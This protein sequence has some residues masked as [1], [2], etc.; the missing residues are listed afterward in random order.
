[1]GTRKV[2][3]RLNANHGRKRDKAACTNQDIIEAS[4]LQ[5]RSPSLVPSC[6]LESY[7]LQRCYSQIEE[8]ALPNF[9]SNAR[10]FFDSHKR[11]RFVH[12][13]LPLLHK[14]IYHGKRNKCEMNIVSHTTLHI[15]LVAI[16]PI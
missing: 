6:K 16:L 8:L 11:D 10:K 14:H 15:V 2:S 5:T 3:K 9:S 13:L 4:I 1:M 7:Q 12:M